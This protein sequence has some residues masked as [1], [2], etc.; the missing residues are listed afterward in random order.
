M[1]I[2]V[3]VVIRK[4]VVGDWRFNYLSGR[5]P[6]S[7]LH[8]ILKIHVTT[9]QVVETSV[10]SNSLYKST[11]TRTITPKKLLITLGSNHL[12]L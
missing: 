9:A 1:I 3:R 4:T 7:H 5:H 10:T 12:P 11:L 8:L 6:Q 2:Q